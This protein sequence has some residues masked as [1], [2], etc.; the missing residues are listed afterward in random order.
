VDLLGSPA[1]KNFVTP[2]PS[3]RWDMLRFSYW[4]ESRILHLLLDE[5][6]LVNRLVRGTQHQRP[7]GHI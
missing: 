5:I 2:Y 1:F 6:D 7:E 3:D 4:L